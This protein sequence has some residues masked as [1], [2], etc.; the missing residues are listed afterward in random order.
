V[1]APTRRRRNGAFVVLAIF[2]VGTLFV[3]GLFLAARQLGGWRRPP[4]TAPTRPA[5]TVS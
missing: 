2:V 5:T 1:T 3:W 4:T